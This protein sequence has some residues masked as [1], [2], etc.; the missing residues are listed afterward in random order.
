MYP[1]T[2]PPSKYPYANGY[3]YSTIDKRPNANRTK[4]KKVY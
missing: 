4:S 2:G 1:R 3:S